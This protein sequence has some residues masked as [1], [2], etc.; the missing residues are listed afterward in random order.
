[1]FLCWCTLWIL[2]HLKDNIFF[3]WE[4]PSDSF[5]TSK[6]LKRLFLLLYVPNI[7]KD[8]FWCEI[9]STISRAPLIWLKQENQ[10]SANLLFEIH[11][12]YW[13]FIHVKG[14]TKIDGDEFY[15]KKLVPFVDH[16]Q[17]AGPSRWS[18]GKG[19]SLRMIICKRPAPPNDHLQEA[20]PHL[21]I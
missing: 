11:T 5:A 8:F 10:N 13:Y 7:F 1:M 19:Q 15:A 18:F 14:K 20:G 17:E 4:K 21:N 9:I 3:F 12:P 6:I 2:T 16:L